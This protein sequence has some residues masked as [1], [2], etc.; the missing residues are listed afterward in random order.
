MKIAIRALNSRV[1]LLKRKLVPDDIG[2][3][4]ETW[5]NL[6][7]TWAHIAPL[8]T[9]GSKGDA[10]KGVRLGGKEIQ[11]LGFK[12]VLNHH[13]KR[14]S[15]ERIKWQGRLLAL[16]A[17]PELEESRQFVVCYASELLISEQGN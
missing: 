13:I 4:Q 2:G 6:T 16:T 9:H 5:E 17:Q 15:F 8:Y 14:L 12:I 11:S 7:K 1:D 3:F 10:A